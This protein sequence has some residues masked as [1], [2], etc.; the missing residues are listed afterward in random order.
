[1]KKYILFLCALSVMLVLTQCRTTK[2]GVDA[3]TSSTQLTKKKLTKS[4]IRYCSYSHSNAMMQM[5]KR[6]SV[7]RVDDN[8]YKLTY[9]QM[10]A[11][12]PPMN[13][14]IETDKKIEK[15]LHKIFKEAK[16]QNCKAAPTPEGPMISDAPVYSFS[17]TF[18]DH[19]EYSNKEPYANCKEIWNAM[20]K[21]DKYILDFVMANRNK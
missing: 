15:D 5:S 17:V 2:N 4:P 18:M 20:E 7:T 9:Y 10:V 6:W 16:I 3:T 21:A 14:E 8:K 1:M 19:T 13:V 12:D 11:N